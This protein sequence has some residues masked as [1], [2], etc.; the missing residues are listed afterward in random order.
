MG[1]TAELDRVTHRHHTH[2]V[3]VLVGKEG[4][5]PLRKSIGEGHLAD[6]DRCVREDEVVHLELDVGKLRGIDRTAMREIE[7]EMFIVY[8]TTF[9]CY[10][11][12]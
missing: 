2:H 10:M 5:C 4:H 12:T 7:T 6:V 8:Q 11:F 9:L 1:A 3:T